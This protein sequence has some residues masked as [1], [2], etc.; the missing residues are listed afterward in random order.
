MVRS[1][2]GL[3]HLLA[4]KADRAAGNALIRKISSVSVLATWAAEHHRSA[5]DRLGAR[6]VDIGGG[7][8]NCSAMFAEMNVIKEAWGFRSG[9]LALCIARLADIWVEDATSRVAA[10]AE[11]TEGVDSKVVVSV[12]E[13]PNLTP[14]GGALVLRALTEGN[15]SSDVVLNI[16]ILKDALSSDSVVNTLSNLSANL[17]LVAIVS[18]NRLGPSWKRVDA[19]AKTLSVSVGVLDITL[20][21]EAEAVAVLIGES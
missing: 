3:V 11:V 16:R 17:D 19:I 6:K 7:L 14:E 12:F 21:A 20:E 4:S 15:N 1:R 10:V 8:N 18:K 9:S 13:S 2:S 5:N